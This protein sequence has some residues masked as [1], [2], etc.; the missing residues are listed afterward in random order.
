METN[1][2][3]IGGILRKAS[4]HKA[5]R[6]LSYTVLK[7]W[8]AEI[9][10]PVAVAPLISKGVWAVIVAI[11]FGIMGMVLSMDRPESENSPLSGL[12][13]WL[14]ELLSFEVHVQP[15]MVMSIVTM[16]VMILLNVLYLSR[17]T[18]LGHLPVH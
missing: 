14:T 15:V 10:A 4:E 2:D 12:G 5:P 3:I 17:R 8:K 18:S 7:A 9:Q 1:K 16:A 6:D 13:T 11:F